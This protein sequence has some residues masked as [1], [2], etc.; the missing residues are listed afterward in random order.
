M[1]YLQ[2][3]INQLA[4]DANHPL[5]ETLTSFQF[6]W[7]LN[8]LQSLQTKRLVFDA[9]QAQV[10]DKSA[11]I[12]ECRREKIKPPFGMFYMELTE[13][14]LLQK[15]EPNQKDRL[16]GILFSQGA[17]QGTEVINEGKD[18]RTV[19]VT[20]VTFFYK[21]EDDRQFIDRSWSVSP[22]GYA[23]VGRPPRHISSRYKSTMP[24]GG[25]LEGAV[26][27][28]LVDP[29]KLPEYVQEGELVSIFELE[30]LG[31]WEECLLSNTNLLYWIFAYT[32]AKSVEIIEIPISRQV[33]RACE[34][35][36]KPLPLPWHMIKVQPKRVKGKPEYV[37]ESGIKHSYRYDVIGFLRFNKHKSKDGKIIETIEWVQDHQRGLNNSLYIP[38]TYV[39]EKNKKIA[40][41]EMDRY[42]KETT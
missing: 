42:F 41:P 17:A 39:I 2:K 20:K 1:R 24:S 29:L 18:R 21:D 9:R 37:G 10:F 33:R 12:D 15:Q 22:E 16:Y 8:N 26:A 28:G 35:Q 23:M 30:E 13:P 3:L 25:Q 14:I 36:D 38:K 19:D 5:T 40:L 31:W 11:E 4:F 6:K 7:L 34:R 27:Q 32:M